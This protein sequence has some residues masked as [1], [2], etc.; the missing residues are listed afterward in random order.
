[1]EHI[2]SDINKAY[3]MGYQNAEIKSN[4]EVTI[5]NVTYVYEKQNN[6]IRDF[7]IGDELRPQVYNY[8]IYN[9]SGKYLEK[10]CIVSTNSYSE[11]STYYKDG[12]QYSTI[13]I[14]QKVPQG[15]LI[16]DFLLPE[17]IIHGYHGETIVNFSLITNETISKKG[18]KVEKIHPGRCHCSNTPRINLLKAQLTYSS[19]QELLNVVN[20]IPRVGADN[21]YN[22]LKEKLETTK[23]EQYSGIKM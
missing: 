13:E 4:E 10:T 3:I 12:K 5:N 15:I 14:S 19:K 22:Q 11:V 9:N 1:M 23:N 8:F 6:L 20:S 2:N 16:A 7:K 21:L 18:Y 17:D